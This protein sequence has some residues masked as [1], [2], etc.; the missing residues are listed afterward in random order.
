MFVDS[1]S[2]TL[3]DEMKD[4]SAVQAVRLLAFDFYGPIVSRPQFLSV[5]S[6]SPRAKNLSAR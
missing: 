3:R 2:H 6:K 4:L 1:V 5:V